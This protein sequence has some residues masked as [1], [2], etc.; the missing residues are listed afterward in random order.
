MVTGNKYRDFNVDLPVL[1]PI[2]P[3]PASPLFFVVK[4]L[5]PRVCPL[6]VAALSFVVKSLRPRVCPLLVAAL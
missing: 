6:L 4:S 2:S 1:S 3:L 5:R